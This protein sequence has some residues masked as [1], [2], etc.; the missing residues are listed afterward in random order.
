MAGAPGGGEWALLFL[1]ILVLFGPRRLP[2]VIQMISRTLHAVRRAAQDFQD[3][4]MAIDEAD[5]VALKS[6]DYTDAE[7]GSIPRVTTESSAA[8]GQPACA[9]LPETAPHEQTDKDGRD[10]Q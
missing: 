1:I 10:V 7:L 9:N 6:T 4:I 5:D 8:S 3:E 2:E